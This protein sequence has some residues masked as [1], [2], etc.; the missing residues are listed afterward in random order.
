MTLIPEG[1]HNS[2]QSFH[3]CSSF[4]STHVLKNVSNKFCCFHDQVL[5]CCGLFYE[6]LP[7]ICE[8]NNYSSRKRVI[9][10][11]FLADYDH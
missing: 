3:S 6:D 1:E 4:L 9:F 11:L 7:R 2:L 10:L 5:M 8:L